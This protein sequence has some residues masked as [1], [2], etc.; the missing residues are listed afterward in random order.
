MLGQAVGASRTLLDSDDVRL[1]LNEHS[2]AKPR[3]GCPLAVS[4]RS[5]SHPVPAE[6]FA[7]G[8]VFWISNP[9]NSVYDNR[10]AGS[11]GTG[12]VFFFFFCYCVS[13]LRP[14]SRGLTILFP[15]LRFWMSF[16]KRLNCVDDGQ[17]ECVV[18]ATKKGTGPANVFPAAQVGLGRWVLLLLSFTQRVGHRAHDASITT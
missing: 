13:L 17:T 1:L 6:R 15:P 8:S 11:E 9:D 14:V 16:V 10:A 3:M 7:P 5:F 18:D 2:S 12:C 4:A